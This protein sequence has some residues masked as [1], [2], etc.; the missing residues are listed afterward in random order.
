MKQYTQEEF[1]NFTR[2]EFDYLQ[3]PPGD[4]RLIKEFP[5]YCSFGEGCSFGG[6]CRFG[7]GCSFGECC[8]FGEDCMAAKPARFFF[9]YSPHAS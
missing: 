8:R 5:A 7:D 9:M 4:Y 6:W 2:D 3:C 1:D